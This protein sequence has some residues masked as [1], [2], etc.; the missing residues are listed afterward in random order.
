MSAGARLLAAVALV[1]VGGVARGQT[2]LDQEERL[3]DI[4]SLLLD[5]PPLQAP[6]ALPPRRLGVSLEAVGIPE[7]DGATGTRR[8]ITA[9]DHARVV[10]RPRVALGLPAP[11]GFRAFAGLSYVP[12]ITFREVDTNALGAEAGLAWVPGRFGLGLRAHAVHATVHAPVTDPATRDVLETWVGGGELSAAARFTVG[13]VELEPYA[14]AGFVSLDG[15][16]RVTS[17]GNVLTS[18]FTG[19]ALHAGVRAVFRGRWELATEVD[20]YP[21]RLVHTDVRLGFLFGP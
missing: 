20:G 8:Q 16:F 2:M 9:S 14:G 7:I 18:A 4:H 13:G 11:A 15:R 3:I 5:L 19:P 21:Q 10:P 12:P 6:G 1:A 17:D